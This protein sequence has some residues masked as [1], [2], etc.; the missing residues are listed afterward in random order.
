MTEDLTDLFTEPEEYYKPEPKL[1]VTTYERNLKPNSEEVEPKSL[2]LSL[3]GSH[4]LWGH[5]LW[6]AAKVLT[7]VLENPDFHLAGKCV[8]ELGAGAGL[9]SLICVLRDAAMVVAT[10]YPDD[11][12]IQNLKSNILSNIPEKKRDKI[13]AKGHIWG[14]N[15]ES[16]LETIAHIKPKFDLILCSDLIVY[17]H[18]HLGLLKTC[19]ECLS[20]NGEVFVVFSHHKLEWVERDLKFFELASSPPFNF[21]VTHKFTKKMNFMFE[22]D[23]S[24]EEL[25]STVY[26]NVLTKRPTP[27]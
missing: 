2:S 26:F 8:L 24:P 4:P 25:K 19:S 22:N 7:E 17:P 14:Q 6:N 3:V 11:P 21:N 10:D 16:L 27:M 5:F 12:L 15:I 9:P 18:S 20:E 1:K 13:V 23:P